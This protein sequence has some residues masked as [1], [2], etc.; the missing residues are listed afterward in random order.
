MAM[1]YG[2]IYVACVAFGA[3]DEQTL[4]AFL[5]AESYDGPALIIAYCH[6]VAHGIEMSQG[7]RSQRAAVDTGQWLLYRYDPRR[8]REGLNPLQLDSPAPRL[9]ARQYFDLEGR[10]NMLRRSDP[11]AADNIFDEAQREAYE[12]RALFDRMA[13]PS[14]P[15]IT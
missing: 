3:R 2:S 6:C 1:T 8:S 5:E 13:A 12:R 14:A 11:E 4:R 7:L 9:K 10:F 15:P